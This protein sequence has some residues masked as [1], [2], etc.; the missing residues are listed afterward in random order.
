MQRDVERADAHED[1][2]CSL[3]FAVFSLQFAV[4][5]LPAES[6]HLQFRQQRKVIGRL[7][8]G[9]F[10][11]EILDELD[12]DVE[13]PRIAVERQ[14]DDVWALFRLSKGYSSAMKG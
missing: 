4:F 9:V 12:E 10:G 14:A 8:T 6:L 3:Q 2:V 7:H 13:P 11:N 1:L 5:Q